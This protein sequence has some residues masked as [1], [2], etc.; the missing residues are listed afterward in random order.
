[1]FYRHECSFESSIDVSGSPTFISLSL[2]DFSFM[3]FQHV[4]RREV[5]F[6]VADQ[7]DAVDVFK[8]G[9]AVNIVD[10]A[11]PKQDSHDTDGRPYHLVVCSLLCVFY[12]IGSYLNTCSAVKYRVTWG[13]TAP[14]SKTA[15]GRKTAPSSYAKYK[16][17]NILKSGAK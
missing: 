6:F 5:S 12:R 15:S 16:I 10:V 11:K 3:S 13:K 14:G 9:S 17:V 8:E 7:V 2:N 4:M 1:M